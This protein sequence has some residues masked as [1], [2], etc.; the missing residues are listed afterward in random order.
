MKKFLFIILLLILILVSFLNIKQSSWLKEGEMQKSSV[1]NPPEGNVGESEKQ[2]YQTPEIYEVNSLRID[3]RL[4]HLRVKTETDT[5]FGDSVTTQVTVEIP[6]KI[7]RAD[8]F[9]FNND[10]KK[11]MFYQV[12]TGVYVF[13]K[14]MLDDSVNNLVFFYR[15][16][17]RRS[18][19]EKLVVIKK[20]YR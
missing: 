12:G 16:G 1:K 7:S 8:I 11:D 19:P 2:D 5:I 4:P 18:L 9:L 17:N 20:F 6:E 15:L 14:V 13:R 10:K 3:S